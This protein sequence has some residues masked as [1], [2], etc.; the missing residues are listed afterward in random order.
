MIHMTLESYYRDEPVDSNDVDHPDGLLWPILME[1][2]DNLPKG[3]KIEC[4][5]DHSEFIVGVDTNSIIIQID[6]NGMYINYGIRGRRE[7]I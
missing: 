5:D 7:S 6:G 2:L 1:E 4:T 3:T